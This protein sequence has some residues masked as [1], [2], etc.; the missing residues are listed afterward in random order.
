MRLRFKEHRNPDMEDRRCGIENNTFQTHD[1]WDF[2]VYHTTPDKVPFLASVFS[3]A[4]KIHSETI[5]KT[6]GEDEKKMVPGEFRG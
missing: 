1:P 5:V 3:S 4:K 2:T 6:K